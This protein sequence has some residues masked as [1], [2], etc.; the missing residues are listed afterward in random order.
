MNHNIGYVF[1]H[2]IYII[3]IHLHRENLHNEAPQAS[4]GDGIPSQGETLHPAP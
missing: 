3:Y 1:F 2:N 4:Y